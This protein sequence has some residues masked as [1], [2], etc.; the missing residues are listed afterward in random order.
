M[1]VCVCVCELAELL[2]S[3][4][5]EGIRGPFLWKR[6][7]SRSS[8]AQV[9]IE[10]TV[11]FCGQTRSVLEGREEAREAK[12][13]IRGSNPGIFK[14]EPG[15]GLDNTT[16]RQAVWLG[17]RW[18]ERERKGSSPA[19]WDWDGCVETDDEFWCQGR[20]GRVRDK[21]WDRQ[22]PCGEGTGVGTKKEPNMACHHVSFGPGA[23][24]V[25]S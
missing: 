6:Q 19:W 16:G 23:L 8:A 24:S 12:A 7:V 10:G 22:G 18:R 13:C 21:S 15:A 3:L 9:M 4:F 17:T 25:V 14:H 11:L 20:A 2:D 5:K 1:C